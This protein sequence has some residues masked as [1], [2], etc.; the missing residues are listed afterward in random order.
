MIALINRTTGTLMWVADDRVDKYLA[1]G[2]RPVANYAMKPQ[3]TE[4]K[5]EIKEE[6]PKETAKDVFEKETVRLPKNR[7][8]YKEV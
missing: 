8:K 2:H 1:A 7:R 5:K 6:K 3:K 4:P